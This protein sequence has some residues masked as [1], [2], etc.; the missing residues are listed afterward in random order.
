MLMHPSAAPSRRRRDAAEAAA[1]A[2][3][4]RRYLN[5][6]GKVTLLSAA[7]EVRLAREIEV[8]VL[9]EE[10]LVHAEPHDDLEGLREL[11]RIGTAAKQHLIEAN[12]RLVVSVARRYSRRGLPLLDVIQ[13]GNVGLIRAV[14]RFDYTKG[15]K[16]STYA[17]WWIRQAITRALADQGRAIRLPVHVTD[18]LNRILRARRHLSR[19]QVDATAA[20]VSAATGIPVERVSELMAFAD[21]PVSLQ[22]PIGAE[23]DSTLGDFVEDAEA[24]SP[25]DVVAQAMLR[26]H[27]E[28]VLAGLT[29]RERD[30]V[31]LRYG[32]D[33]GRSRT[34]EEV[35][36]YF[37]VTRERIRQ[38]EYRTLRKLRLTDH[39]GQLR[40][41]LS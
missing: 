15:F 1:G 29:P 38:I 2:D 10:R 34:L 26:E 7:D 9:A 32:L 40:D 19:E 22:T 25:A 37:G 20:D 13:E 39:A 33:D 12:L 6:I 41:Y 21:E 17:T 11:V 16:F 27:V 30:I 14:E 3:L 18:E 24:A 8:G 31:R 5:E 28:A 4:V 35:G 23:A 36:R